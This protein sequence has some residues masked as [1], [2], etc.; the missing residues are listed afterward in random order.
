M[1]GSLT[2]D[3]GS[4]DH[5]TGC[6]K[7]KHSPSHS[8]EQ[9]RVDPQ[10]RGMLTWLLGLALLALLALLPAAIHA[11]TLA[12]QLAARS[13][14][15]IYLAACSA[16]H[17]ETGDGAPESATVFIRPDTFPHFDR[18]DETT[19][20]STKDWTATVR[21]G[22]VARG[23]SRI[24]PAFTQVLSKAEINRVVT[25]LRGLCAE[26][27]RP[28]GELNVPRALLTEKAFPESETVL[29]A[30][31]ATSGPASVMNELDYEKTLGHRDQL[32]VAAPFGWS[33]E[34]SGALVGGLGDV[35][36]GI[37]H[38]LFSE[39][40]ALPEQPIF[41][42]TGSILSVQAELTLPTGNPR[43]GLGTGV[44]GA[45]LFLA[46]DVVLPA[47]SFVQLQMGTDLPFSTR[48]G[49]RSVYF[50]SALGK[51]F[52]EH[53]FGRMWSPMVEMVGTRDLTGGAVT[54][55][56]LIPELQVTLNRRQHIRA[57]LGYS[58]PLTDT[59]GRP[60]QIMAYFLWDWFDG[61]LLEGWR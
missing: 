55:W 60:H 30:T 51:S 43:A 45:G 38:V 23:F 28:R 61:G 8:Q 53:E 56:D 6:G 11:Q 44:L 13:G 17:G 54:D 9:R 5:H 26:P 52:S 33:R 42:A 16:C 18:C 31:A 15:E 37:K 48:N 34:P 59:A 39:L 50:R 49:P 46:Y 1:R 4:T 27:D 41:D 36:V 58:F 40:H 24:M 57:A 32:E 22:G 10:Q 47:Q 29:T 20:E 12:Q 14:Q 7:E 25:Y 19:P 2:P 3:R 35:A 21:D